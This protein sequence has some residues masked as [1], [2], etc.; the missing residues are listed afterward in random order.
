MNE[1][2]AF[3]VDVWIKR[4]MEKLFNVRGSSKKITEAG[5]RLF[6]KYAG[7]AQEY[8]YYYMR[9]ILRSE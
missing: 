1:P 4:G 2:S 5:R 9:S 6:G 3:P 8:M 7:Y